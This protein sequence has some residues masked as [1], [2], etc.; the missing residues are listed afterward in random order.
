ML[1]GGFSLSALFSHK[2]VPA[3]ASIK[4]AQGAGVCDSSFLAAGTCALAG[5]ASASKR[6]SAEA[7]TLRKIEGVD[8]K[9]GM[10]APREAGSRTLN[11]MYWLRLGFA[12]PMRQISGAI[13]WILQR[14]IGL[15]SATATA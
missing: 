12:N 9:T 7:A 6:H 11:Q 13:S 14:R 1:A 3:S 4:I 2:T 8:S 15:S 5:I 10:T